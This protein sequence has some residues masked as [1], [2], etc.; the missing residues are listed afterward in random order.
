VRVQT[1]SDA[2]D[3]AAQ[4]RIRTTPVAWL[5]HASLTVN[6]WQTVGPRIGL[7][8]KSANW[9]LGDWVRFGQRRYDQRYQRASELTGYDEQTLMNLAYVAGRFEISRRRE[10]VPWS[11]HAELAKLDVAD[12]ELWLNRVTTRKLSVRKLRAE[13]RDAE[14]GAADSETSDSSGQEVR[15]LESERP[16]HSIVCPHCGEVFTPE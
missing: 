3:A 6:E 15:T 4:R 11:H 8:S 2:R 10:T 9:W 5:G 12:Q 1:Q 13:L 7:A 14:R 16:A